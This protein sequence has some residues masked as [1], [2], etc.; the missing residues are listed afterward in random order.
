MHRIH[1]KFLKLALTASLLFW[2]GVAGTP[3]MAASG[4]FSFSGLIGGDSSLQAGLSFPGSVNVDYTLDFDS[5]TVTTIGSNTGSYDGAIRNLEVKIGGYTAS[6]VPNSGS[7][8]IEIQQIPNPSGFD[9][10]LMKANIAGNSVTTGDGIFHPLT[11]YIDFTRPPGAFGNSLTPPTLGSI[12]GVANY[13]VVFERGNGILKELNGS[14]NIAAVPLP[15]AVILFGAGLVALIGLGAR[16]W[17][18]KQL[19]V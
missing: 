13:H 14:G 15:P 1:S 11:L 3:A 4:A 18:R 9:H 19:E 2:A 12:V 16:N 6:L 5:P 17:Q 10:F 8:F 7:N